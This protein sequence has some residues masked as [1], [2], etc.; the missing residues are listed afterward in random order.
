M[1]TNFPP[2]TVPP[3]PTPHVETHFSATALVRDVVIGMSD[4]LTV[5][6]ALAA[7][8]SGAV[9]SAHVVV[10]AGLAEIAA[11]TVSLHQLA[12]S[13]AP[14]YRTALDAGGDYAYRTRGEAHL[15]EPRGRRGAR[16]AARA[17]L[18]RQHDVLQ[19]RERGNQMKGLK[20]E[21]DMLPAQTRAA[22]L[23]EPR[24]FHPGDPHFARAG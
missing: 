9:N 11:E 23:I 2:V 5:P 14:L 12:Y 22:V 21:A 13:D 17:K 8:L 3:T 19:R 15:R 4:G 10:L 16:V 20:H 7:G 6:F 1:A 24:H 18:Q